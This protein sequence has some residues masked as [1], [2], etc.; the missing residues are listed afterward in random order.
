MCHLSG[1]MAVNDDLYV[2]NYSTFSFFTHYEFV[3]IADQ[4]SQ[5]SHLV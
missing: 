3:V 4:I 2:L 5:A 1:Y